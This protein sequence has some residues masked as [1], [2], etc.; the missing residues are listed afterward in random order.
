MQ[1]AH[2]T[3][4]QQAGLGGAVEVAQRPEID[5]PHAHTVPKLAKRTGS[6]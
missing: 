3:T 6:E 5:D 1:V 4:R 2:P